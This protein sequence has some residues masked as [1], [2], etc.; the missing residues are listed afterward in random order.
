[1]AYTQLNLHINFAGSAR[2]SGVPVIKKVETRT[3][4]RVVVKSELDGTETITDFD[5][6]NT[7]QQ[8]GYALQRAYT[9]ILYNVDVGSDK[10]LNVFL[11]GQVSGAVPDPVIQEITTFPSYPYLAAG[12]TETQET[13][14]TTPTWL[15]TAETTSEA[16]SRIRSAAVAHAR[17]C[18]DLM[19]SGW[20]VDNTGAFATIRNKWRNT[21]L[22]ILSGLAV[23]DAILDSTDSAWDED[24]AQNALDA[25]QSLIPA[26]RSNIETWYFAHTE[27][28][29]NVYFTENSGNVPAY[30]NWKRGDT[31]PAFASDAAS[32]VLWDGNNNTLDVDFS[33]SASPEDFS[34]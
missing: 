14:D 22:W 34:S 27:A 19:V 4:S 24:V 16:K 30:F 28:I 20:I 29:W 11:A 9:D 5:L 26:D 31:S 7:P 18:F 2:L 23:I 12:E 13:P 25:Y 15:P 33:A 1:M 32:S 6:S 3:A 21:R 10:Q 8:V 17:I